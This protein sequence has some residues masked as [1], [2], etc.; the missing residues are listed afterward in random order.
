M[1]GGRPL[2]QLGVVEEADDILAQNIHVFPA[3]NALPT[4]DKERLLAWASRYL[5][6]RTR[7]A[8]YR[9]VAAS[10][11]RWPRT[12]VVDR[13]GR[14]IGSNEIPHALKVGTAELAR[15]LMV[16]DRSAERDQD[17]L[18]RL[19]ADAIELE[20]KDGYILP[21]VPEHLRF[22]LAGLGVVNTGGGVHCKRIGGVD[23]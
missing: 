20:F 21:K 13:D 3:W 2:S 9:A 1:P 7:W 10:G 14:A 6:D 16:A 15:H 12:G 4:E 11:L 18:S 19:K 23:V 22:V 17:G 5:D 8:G